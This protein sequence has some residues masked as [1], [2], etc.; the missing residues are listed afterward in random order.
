MLYCIVV[1]VMNDSSTQKTSTCASGPKNLKVNDNTVVNGHARQPSNKT[2]TASEPNV[3][4]NAGAG[5]LIWWL[6]VH[7]V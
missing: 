3:A 4:T 1:G 5:M 6:H 7:S 2:I